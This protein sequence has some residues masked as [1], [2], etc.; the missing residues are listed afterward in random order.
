L[1]LFASFAI[2]VAHFFDYSRNLQNRA[3]AAALAA[4]DAFGGICFGANPTSSQTDTIGQTA[5]QY[6]GPPN[7]TP[8][9]NLPFGATLPAG[10]QPYQNQPNLT[11][12][13]PA[14]YHLLLNSNA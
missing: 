1:A 10:F 14:N 13:T 4:G 2:D 11:K 6:S 5:Q 7:G 12:G 3:D 8:G 9:G